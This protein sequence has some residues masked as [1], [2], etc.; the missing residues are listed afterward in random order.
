MA[1]PAWKPI[2]W[3][4]FFPPGAV[5]FVKGLLKNYLA[6]QNDDGFIDWK[7]GLA[8]QQSF[9]LSTPIL[10]A[11][12]W[13]IYSIC[14]DDAFIADIFPGLLK[15]FRTWFF[16]RRDRDGDGIPEWDHLSQAGLEVH[17]AY[18]RWQRW[19]AGTDISS[20]E[21]PSLN[22][23][24]YQECQCLI[25]MA[26]IIGNPAQVADLERDSERLRLAVEIAFDVNRGRYQDVDRD[27]HFS[28]HSEPI[29]ERL[30]P[31]II[32][33]NRKFEHPIR[34]LIHIF[35]ENQTSR[36]PRLI[37]HGISASGQPRL[38]K[39][40]EERFKW[41]SGRGVFTGE[42]VY[43]VL[44]KIEIGDIHE[45]DHVMIFSAGYDHCD[46]TSLLPLWA[47]IPDEERAKILIEQTIH[48][49]NLFWRPAGLPVSLEP[50]SDPDAVLCQSANMIWNTLIGEGLVRYGF[51]E[52]AADLVSRLMIG[53]IKNL[54]QDNAFRQYYHAET[55]MGLGEKNTL[56][57][58]APLSL[59]METLG[60][61]LLS[62]QKV[63]LTGYNPFP[64]PVTVK[65]RGLTV[66]RLKDKS[67]VI[68]PDGQ[69]VAIDNPAAQ[70]VSLET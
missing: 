37:I 34:P 17:V 58:L 8:G 6:I 26:K 45:D 49:P 36:R 29:A 55:G 40:M 19:S 68:F 56:Q 61:R 30:G 7:P 16:P 57:G 12:A 64:W 47:G 52:I 48:N 3:Q 53:V 25:Q 9:I 11:I 59:F 60:V 4:D 14:A 44:E 39:V 67:T 18:S 21:S 10:A 54:K 43:Q 51:R 24:L 65:Y 46:L 62:N 70:I 32:E 23:F 2:T 1:N 35:S 42:R 33:I 20:A 69:A 15:F 13:K 28:T 31:G 38:E 5:E 41:F 22:A 63:I 27:T 50:P 66:L